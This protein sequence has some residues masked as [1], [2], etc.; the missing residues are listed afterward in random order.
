[1]LVDHVARFPNLYD[2]ISGRNLLWFSAAE[3]FVTISGL[4]VGYVYAHKILAQPKATTIKLWRR[5]LI[6]YVAVISLALFFMLYEHFLLHEGNFVSG[7]TTMLGLLLQLFTLQYS[8]G[9]AEFLTHYVVFLLLAPAGLYL[10]AKRKVLILLGLS[11]VVWV[12]HLWSTVD[13]SRYEFTAS[14]QFLFFIGMIVGAHLLSINAWVRSRFSK[15][16]IQWSTYGLWATAVVIFLVSSFLTYGATMLSQLPG[17]TNL[18]TNVN[19]FWQPVNEGF[20][21]WWTDKAT[22]APLRILFGI[23]I[24]W[25]LFTFFHRFGLQIHRYTNGVLLTLGQQPLFAYCFG[26]VL[27]FCV[28]KYIPT[29]GKPGFGFVA[30]FLVTSAVLF[31]TYSFTKLFTRYMK[32]RSLRSSEFRETIN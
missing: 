1:M 5:A 25:A 12:A 11:C 18:A 17:L 15:K 31:I 24:F 30:N 2:F 26:A 20:F 8:Y 16:T 10:I 32:T 14:W 9:W 7:S 3:G 23:V 27:I 6:L 28:E 21:S 13:Q 19:T 4:L 22:A 29:P